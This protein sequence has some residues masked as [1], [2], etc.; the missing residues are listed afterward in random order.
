MLTTDHCQPCNCYE[1]SHLNETDTESH[2]PTRTKHRQTHQ[3]Y[4][5]VPEGTIVVV[6]PLNGLFA[7]VVVDVVDDLEVVVEMVVV[8]G[9]VVSGL[10]GSV[11]GSVLVG[12]RFIG[13]GVGGML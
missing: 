3:R 7:T 1:A 2:T 11:F 9:V 5:P 10:V 12:C 13:L 4:L 6:V 8:I